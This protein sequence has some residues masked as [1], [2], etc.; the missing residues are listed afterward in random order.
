[1]IY[2]IIIDC[3]CDIGF[4]SVGYEVHV[5]TQT[6]G[7]IMDDFKYLY[8]DET[9]MKFFGKYDNVSASKYG[10]YN[11]VKYNTSIY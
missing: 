1:M 7:V 4:F 11:F 6:H 8:H 5:E 9:N 3:L 2:K 10:I